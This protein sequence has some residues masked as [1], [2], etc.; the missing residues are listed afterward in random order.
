MTDIKT[1]SREYYTQISRAFNGDA[2]KVSLGHKY[3]GRE[4]TE[5]S[6]LFLSFAV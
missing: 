1:T 3:G 6:D 2:M 5:T 4:M